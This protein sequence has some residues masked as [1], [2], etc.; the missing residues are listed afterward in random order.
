MPCQN[1]LACLPRADNHHSYLNARLRKC[2]ELQKT[3]ALPICAPPAC[4][5]TCIRRK[6]GAST[7]DKHAS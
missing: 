2:K 3:S 6:V 7:C 1:K 4:L 5:Q